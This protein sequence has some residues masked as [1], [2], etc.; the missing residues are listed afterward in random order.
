MG[1]RL[2]AKDV[3]SNKII[4]SFRKSDK[5]LHIAVLMTQSL[6]GSGNLKTAVKAR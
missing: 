2:L 1:A 6:S 5:V 3:A 4:G